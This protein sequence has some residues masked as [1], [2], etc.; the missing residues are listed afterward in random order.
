MNEK[1]MDLGRY[2][3]FWSLHFGFHIIIGL[4]ASAAGIVVIF[5]LHEVLNGLALI[6]AGS[7]AIINGWQGCKELR[8]KTEK[9]VYMN[10]KESNR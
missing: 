7:V 9:P 10:S 8:R 2:W 3:P 4:V 1:S 5:T 6:G